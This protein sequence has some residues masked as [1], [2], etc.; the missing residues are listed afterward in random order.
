MADLK[1]DNK[2]DRFIYPKS[3]LNCHG[4]LT[5]PIIVD[6]YSVL[7]AFDVQCPALAHLIKKSLCAG[8]RGHKNKSQDLQDIIDSAVRAKELYNRQ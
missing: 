5:A 7:K 8:L 2:Y 3:R 4:E 6:V 1:L